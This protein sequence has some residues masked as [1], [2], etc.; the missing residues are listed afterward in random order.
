MQRKKNSSVLRIAASN[1]IPVVNCF[2]EISAMINRAIIAEKNANASL[3][4]EFTQEDIR[5]WSEL[6]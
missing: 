5:R 1:E 6:S 2:S 4:G 3:Y